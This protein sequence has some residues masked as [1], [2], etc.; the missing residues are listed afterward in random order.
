MILPLLLACT[1][2]E[3]APVVTEDTAAADEDTAAGDTDS[4][5]E[6]GC[7]PLA[8]LFF[9]LGD[10]LVA[11][12]TDGLYA[13][14]P[15]VI[16]LLDALEARGLPLGVITNVPGNWGRPEL[17]ALL[18][19][20]S[21][22]DRFDVVLL[23]AEASASKPDPVIFAEAVALLSTPSL[24]EHTAFMTEELGHLAE[25][26]P[27]TE[28]AQAAG[29]VGVHLSEGAGSLADYTVAPDDL[30]SLATAAWLDCL[31]GES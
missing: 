26:D 4:G 6:P 5:A 19:D 9:D 3:L 14:L 31:E 8:A 27:P 24:I 10:T 12:G 17:E 23:S 2:A 1:S 13:A 22:L 30:T 16:T 29:M 7:T 18:A 11:E 21:I 28:G 20:P 15:G 25:A